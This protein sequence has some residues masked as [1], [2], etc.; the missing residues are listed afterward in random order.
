MPHDDDD[1]AK[2]ISFPVSKN[3]AG[4]KFFVVDR[5]AFAAAC[6]LGLN[7]AVAYLTVVR[8]AGSRPKSL[9]SVDAIERYTGIS[10]PKAKL[11]V[12][13]LLDNGLLSLE[14][15]GTRPLYG[16]VPAHELP[17]LVLS[18]D[19]RIV[20]G[21]VG[22][23]AIVPTSHYV[24]AYGLLRRDFLSHER[25][26]WS[27]KNSELLSSEPQHV[28]LP[29]AIIEGA[30]DETPPVALLRQMQD[31]RRLQL[32][33]SLYDTSDLPNDGGVS[34]LALRRTHTLTKIGQRGAST[35][36]GFGHGIQTTSTGDLHQHFL[37]G[38]HEAGKDTGLPD[39]W[40]A[41][42]GL[43][44]CGLIEF[45]PHVFESDKPEAEMLHAYPVED[46]GCEPW[47]RSV[48]I[49]AH[50][51]GLVCLTPGRQQWAVEQVRHL[52]P[53]PSHITQLA[54]IGIGRL[55]YR[56]QTRMT[57]AWF[58]KSKERSEA[59]Q[60]VYER[61]TRNEGTAGK[62]ASE[63]LQHKGSIKGTIKDGIKGGIKGF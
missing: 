2:I 42:T 37:T 38:K 29:N 59:W 5:R 23:G 11:A 4:G 16:I 40:A 49:A 6:R 62:I 54:V 36:W 7:P 52:L 53:V 1:Q 43:E 18:V 21:L 15:A 55:R 32:F 45:I 35:I 10:R 41:L 57:A 28:W 46:G 19:D 56:P 24:T 13:T 31:V 26:R 12:T 14:R 50:A 34:R 30:A 9:W 22:E 27:L 61:I 63:P 58:A 33:V 8:G 51:A 44:E 47:E 20:L 25:K 60:T 39:F 48:A 17:N 3:T